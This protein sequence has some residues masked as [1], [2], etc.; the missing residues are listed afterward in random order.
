MSNIIFIHYGNSDYLQYTLTAARFFNPNERI[1]LL[2]DKENVNICKQVEVEHY[3]FED[4]NNGEELA[5]F[6]KVYTFIA[7][8]KHG[9]KAWT[10]FVFKRWFYIYN[11]IVSQSINSFWTFDSDNLILT[12]LPTQEKKFIGYDCTEQCAGI[13]MNGF[14]SN[15]TIVKGYVD[16]I[17]EL[18]TRED[19]ISKIKD[20][21]VDHPEWAFTEMRAY[22]IYRDESRLNSIRLNT[23]IENETFDDCICFSDGMVTNP[24][25]ING[26]HLK[27]IYKYSDGGLYCKSIKQKNFIKL[28]SL[29]MSWV[30]TT[31]YDIILKAAMTKVILPQISPQQKDANYELLEIREPIVMQI[32]RI[33]MSKFTSTALYFKRFQFIKW[34]LNG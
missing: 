23:I 7:G 24:K 2:G 28:N 29:N 26:F 25:T 19:Y 12:F 31:L 16:K 6:D 3:Y 20:E 8:T 33:A 22:T 14:V 11:F 21:F 17:N 15:R 34:M 27:Q 4:F 18:F 13:C 10:N 1:I 32:K 9:R 5:Q 30:P